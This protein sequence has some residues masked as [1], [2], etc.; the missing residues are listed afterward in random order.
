[1]S[2]NSRDLLLGLFIGGLIG[3][4]LGML[5]APKSGKEKQEDICPQSKRRT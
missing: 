4:A 3:V 1:M 5:F 2:E